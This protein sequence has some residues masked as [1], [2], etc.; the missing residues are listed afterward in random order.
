MAA[1]RFA[2]PIDSSSAPVAAATFSSKGVKQ[3]SRKRSREEQGHSAAAVSSRRTDPAVVVAWHS[4][5]ASLT[6]FE[7]Q[8]QQVEHSFAFSFVEGVLVKAIR[9]GHWILLDEVLWV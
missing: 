7:S 2:A 9:E 3:K 5:A 4:F 6:R 1:S 8:R